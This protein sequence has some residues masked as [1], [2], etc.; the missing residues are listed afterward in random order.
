MPLLQHLASLA[1]LFGALIVG[2]LTAAQVNFEASRVLT[3][4]LLPFYFVAWALQYVFP[5][6]PN[7]FEK[8]EVFNDMLNNGMLVLISGIQD[9]GVRWL[10]VFAA[11]GLLFHYGLVDS[12]YAL[13]TQPFWVQVLVDV[14]LFDFCFYWTHR[15]AHE[16]DWLWRLHS[17]HHCAHRL[18]VLNASRA[19]P[20]DLFWRR[21][22]P[23]FVVLQTGISPEAFI[24]AG[25]I[26]SV[27]ATITHMNVRFRFG[28]LNYFIGTNEVH[29]WHHST[30]LEEAKNFSMILI[31]DRL[32]GTFVLPRNHGKPEALGLVDERGYPL[33][34]Y[35]GQLMVPF[36]WARLGQ[37]GADKAAAAS[38]QPAAAA[39]GVV[40]AHSAAHSG[41]QAP[42]PSQRG[43]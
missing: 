28:W 34:A 12:A 27:L 3:H 10:T 32:F 35:L 22:V 20:L 9:F 16:R 37:E 41:A 7:R 15:L 21:F 39:M 24:C 33:H 11:P 36:R 31:W 29:I 8:G 5:W 13:H 17:V 40:A 25:V 38:G 30:K 2:V 42:R 18:S 43:A 26:S 6:T 19:H 4:F 1:F 14:L 23:I